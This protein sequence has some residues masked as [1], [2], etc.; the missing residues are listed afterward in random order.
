[1]SVASIDVELT[2]ISEN[3]QYQSGLMCATTDLVQRYSGTPAN[4]QIPED[5]NWAIKKPVLQVL[6]S[7]ASPGMTEATLKNKM[8][9]VEWYVNDAKINFPQNADSNGKRLSPNVLNFPSGTFNQ[10]LHGGS[11]YPFGGLQ[12]L[13]N[14]VSATNGKSAVVKAVISFEDNSGS[15][16]VKQHTFTLGV[17]QFAANEL[18]LDIYVTA[19]NELILTQAKPT[20]QLS[21]RLYKGADRI[22]DSADSTKNS[23]YTPKFYAYDGTTANDWKIIQAAGSGDSL[24]FAYSGN[25][26][27]VGRDGVPTN[28]LV[29]CALFK[30]DN[31]SDADAN[32][33]TYMQ[34]EA[35]GYERIND[36][37]DSLFIQ[38]TQN[39]ADGV[40]RAGET[41]PDGVTILPK[42]M[43]KDSQSQVMG[44]K[45][46]FLCM[47]PA[48]TIL[49]GTSAQLGTPN[50]PN[51]GKP[52]DSNNN[53][54]ADNTEFFT[55]AQLALA[56]YKVPRAMMAAI[57]DVVRV[58]IMAYLD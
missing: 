21:V 9:Q 31:V 45:F 30:G 28:L 41:T 37:T 40:L 1:M 43:D 13:G 24:E 16:V 27:I 38:V 25:E 48:G 52:I 22:Y 50:P 46:K 49:N 51:G 29:M 26:L 42:L 47:S 10:I 19:P 44:A 5:Y 11:D 55:D 17:R 2:Y 23:G 58:I 57:G 36:K 35:I 3:E 18:T 12:I 15:V 33:K 53:N 14:I 8:L 20:T 7:S 39:P 4:P 34:A 6:L 56:P 54:T 32:T